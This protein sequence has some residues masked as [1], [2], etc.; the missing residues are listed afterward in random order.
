MRTNLVI[1]LFSIFLTSCGHHYYDN[2]K[3]GKDINYGGFGF[4]QYDSYNTFYSRQKTVLKADNEL[5]NYQHFDI[6]VPK[7]IKKWLYSG[8]TL[9]IEYDDNQIIS[10]N[11][12]TKIKTDKIFEWSE[13]IENADLLN[14]I[15]NYYTTIHRKKWD[16]EA[17]TK[18]K[19][20]T[21][22]YNDGHSTIILF[23]IKKENI[24]R[25]DVIK[26]SFKYI[27]SNRS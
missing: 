16:F 9:I 17:E 15:S 6:D 11:P 18:L 2:P 14:V 4:K 1:L 12:K 25:F 7:N 27:K 26:E 21:K 10:I 5:S 20:I 22:I 19:R 24:E 13:L 3:F 23:N 8:T